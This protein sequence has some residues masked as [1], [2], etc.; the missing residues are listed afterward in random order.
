MNEVSEKK[1]IFAPILELREALELQS[2]TKHSFTPNTQYN[3]K[4][5]HSPYR[6]VRESSRSI[7]DLHQWLF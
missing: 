5:F 2:D 6:K 7:Y 4:D 3:E 1:L